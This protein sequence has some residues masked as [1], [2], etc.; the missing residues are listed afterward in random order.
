[1]PQLGF[2]W[3]GGP[4]FMVLEVGIMALFWQGCDADNVA[5]K[6]E[7]MMH[8]QRGNH[9]HAAKR[10]RG[11]TPL[12]RGAGGATLSANKHTLKVMHP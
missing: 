6:E 7:V 10:C 9:H 11:E 3:I 8:H 1:M 2:E 12:W 4:E 5:D